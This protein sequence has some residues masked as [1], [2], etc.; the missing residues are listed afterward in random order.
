[1]I[2]GQCV[3]AVRRAVRLKR[4]GKGMSLMSLAVV[5]SSFMMSNTAFAG[6]TPT[7]TDAFYSLYQLIINWVSGAPG[8]IGAI[9]ILIVGVYGSMF[10]GKS[11]MFFFGA[12][13]GAGL[14]FLLPG[15]ATS[16]AGATF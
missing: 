4:K 9:V 16:L 14:I 3:N 1:M 8:I 13:L 7:T 12:A 15:I 2:F 10:A 6:T 11:P 5:M